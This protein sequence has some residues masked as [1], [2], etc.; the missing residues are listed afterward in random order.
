MFAGEPRS[1]SLRRRGAA[2]RHNH[3]QDSDCVFEKLALFFAE[4]G[5]LP[6]L[7]SWTPKVTAADWL[8]EWLKTRRLSSVSGA[9]RLSADLGMRA[10]RVVKKCD[11]E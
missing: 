10:P 4:I 8:S 9:A 3:Q 1:V 6:T 5:C 7:A 11:N 2:Q